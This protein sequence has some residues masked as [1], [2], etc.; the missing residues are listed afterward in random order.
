MDV[1]HSLEASLLVVPRA[2]RR[3]CW[4]SALWMMGPAA[5]PKLAEG[6]CD[7]V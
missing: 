4:A 2:V 1:S 3:G 5:E 6:I 7:L